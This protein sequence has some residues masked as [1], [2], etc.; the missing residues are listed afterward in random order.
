MRTILIVGIGAGNPEFLTL[1][2]ISALQRATVVFLPEKGEEKA[3]RGPEGTDRSAREVR[4]RQRRLI[5]SRTG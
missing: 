4:G 3:G 1:Q 5:G 2:A